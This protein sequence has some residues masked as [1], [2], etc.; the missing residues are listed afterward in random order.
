M[1]CRYT[2]VAPLA[3]WELRRLYR[4]GN[5]RSMPQG[6]RVDPWRREKP[7]EGGQKGTACP[8][9]SKRWRAGGEEAR[10]KMNGK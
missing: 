1:R 6:L 8:R 7:L 10:Q 5:G 4:G 9:H 3:E 2:E